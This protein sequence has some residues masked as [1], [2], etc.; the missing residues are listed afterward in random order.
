MS[1]NYYSGEYEPVVVS[2]WNIYSLLLDLF[3]E[4][5]NQG[6]VHNDHIEDVYDEFLETLNL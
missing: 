4:H 3:T 2:R 1:I 5:T 6:V